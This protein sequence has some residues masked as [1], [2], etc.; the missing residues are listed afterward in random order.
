MEGLKDLPENLLNP[1]SC[2]GPL[3]INFL[4]TIPTFYPTF[5]FLLSNNF[6]LPIRLLYLTCLFHSSTCLSSFSC[7]LPSSVFF[8]PSSIFCLF[9]FISCLYH[10]LL[11]IPISFLFAFIRAYLRH[12]PLWDHFT[13]Y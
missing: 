11:Y 7:Q 6:L 1:Q 5:R 8:L 13:V 4:F 3:F 2:G 10:L 9:F 12:F